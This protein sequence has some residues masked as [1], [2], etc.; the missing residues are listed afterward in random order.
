MGF[1]LHIKNIV[2]PRCIKVVKDEFER[3]NIPTD[4]IESGIVT[5]T[6]ELN[7]AQIQLV[8]QS[9][10]GNGFELIDD[11]RSRLIDNIKTL[12]IENIHHSKDNLES[13]NSSAYISREI[14]YDYS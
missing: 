10:E 3:L 8:K 9:L 6:F 13:I 5:T 7:D 4:S 1:K 2:C 12:I 14:G 11:K